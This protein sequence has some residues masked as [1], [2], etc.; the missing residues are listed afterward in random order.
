ML[1][2]RIKR[3]GSPSDHV[4]TEFKC[5]RAKIKHML[6]DSRVEYRIRICACHYYNSKRFWSFFKLKSKVSITPRKVSA[7]V[8]DSERINADANTGIANMF[9][10]YFAFIV[11]TDSAGISERGQSHNDITIEDI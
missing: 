3:S 6:R 1:R 4:K 2:A 7:K 8:N 11:N 9:N 5:L 10:E